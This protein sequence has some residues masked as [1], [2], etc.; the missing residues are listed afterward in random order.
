MFISKRIISPNT[1]ALEQQLNLGIIEN[2]K[3]VLFYE[4]QADGLI[5]SS[6]QGYRIYC[7]K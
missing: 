2:Q 5:G 3:K 7:T 6:W 4:A 1:L